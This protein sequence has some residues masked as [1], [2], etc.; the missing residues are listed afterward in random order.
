[1]LFVRIIIFSSLKKVT[2]WLIFRFMIKKTELLVRFYILKFGILFEE[3]E[4]G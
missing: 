3:R 1:M 4:A 2:N